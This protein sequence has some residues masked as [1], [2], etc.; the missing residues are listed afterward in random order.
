[1][2]LRLEEKPLEIGGRVYKLRCNMAVLDALEAAHGG[3]ISAMFTLPP[4][5]G[6]CEIMAAMLNDY[7]EDMGWEQDWTSKKV[8]K[9]FPFSAILE[10]DVMGLF[11]R[12]LTPE[13][14]VPAPETET[15]GG[16]P[17]N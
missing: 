12:A 16:D 10:A 5:Q 8:S 7:A 4:R 2:R 13:D 17:G 14:A 11:Q 3:E 6:A 15:P 1:M 9:T